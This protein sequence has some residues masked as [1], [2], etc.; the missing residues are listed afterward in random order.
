M[1][2]FSTADFATVRNDLTTAKSALDMIRAVPNPYYANSGYEQNQ[3]ES[4]IKIINLPKECTVSIYTV[5]GT[6]VR[7]FTKDSPITSI[8]W[9]LNNHQKIPV[10]SGVYLIH[11]DAP[12]I[13]EK[14]VKWFGTIRQLDLNSF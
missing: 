3:L 9:D 10:A 12:G 2:T 7:R 5:N 8:D 4:I 14:V 6:L 11:V 1:Y 13:G